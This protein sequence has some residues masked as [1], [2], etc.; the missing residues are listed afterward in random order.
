MTSPSARPCGNALPRPPI[1]FPPAADE[2]G[3]DEDGADEDGADEDGAVEEWTDWDDLFPTQQ[4]VGTLCAA[5][6]EDDASAPD[7]DYDLH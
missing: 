4:V 6:R 5:D 1:R 3:A 7:Y 2:D